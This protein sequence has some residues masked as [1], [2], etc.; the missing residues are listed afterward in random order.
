MGRSFRGHPLARSCQC[1]AHMA[2]VVW[3]GRFLHSNE[4]L[5]FVDVLVSPSF[6]THGDH[7]I[8]QYKRSHEGDLQMKMTGHGHK[9][10]I[11]V[12]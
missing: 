3:D 7:Q 10:D 2:D 6:P 1:L 8:L 11:V 12:R 9:Y 5:Q 4:L